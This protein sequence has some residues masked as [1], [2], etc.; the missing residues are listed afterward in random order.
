MAHWSELSPMPIPEL[1]TSS[2]GEIMS[3]EVGWILESHLHARYRVTFPMHNQR[4]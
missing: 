2:L 1:V 4:E 3:S